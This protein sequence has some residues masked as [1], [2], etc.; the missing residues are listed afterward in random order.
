MVEG[1]EEAGSQSLDAFLTQYREQ[2]AADVIVLTDTANLDEGIPALTVSL[3]G[4]VG[5]F[6]ETQAL[7]HPIHSGMWGGPIPDPVVALAR[8]IA[9]LTDPDGQLIA[10]FREEVR[11]L[12]REERTALEALPCDLDT[13]RGQIG[14]DEGARLVGDATVPFW[15]RIWRKPSLSV[16]AF[17]A[18]PIEGSS[19]QIVESARA[20]ISV[21]TVPD[22]DPRRT[23]ELLVR[24]F[25]TQVPWGV[26]VRIRR[27]ALANWWITHPSGPAFEAAK[28]A[29]E[30]GYEAPAVYI[31]CGGSIPFVEPFARALGG[32]PALLMGVEDPVCNAHSENESLS[33]ADFKKGTRS[34]IYL[35]EELARALSV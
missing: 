11:P 9:A 21:R 35:Y 4:L 33:I 34:A 32:V 8:A 1:E 6:V 18:R 28:K 31:G 29:L 19:N 25:E 15:A 14:L 23:Q 2:L 3:R 27:E 16:I 12:T 7:D 17:E 20:R 24:H 26:R 5:I 10:P 22:M 13:L 30:R